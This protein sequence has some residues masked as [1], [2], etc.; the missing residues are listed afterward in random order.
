MRKISRR[1]LVAEIFNQSPERFHMR[2]TCAA[3]GSIAC[4]ESPSRMVLP[5][6]LVQRERFGTSAIFHLSHLVAI[7]RTAERGGQLP[8]KRCLTNAMSPSLVSFS[9]SDHLSDEFKPYLIPHSSLTIVVLLKPEQSA[10]KS[11]LSGLTTNNKASIADPSEWF[12][13]L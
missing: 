6:L 12:K 10:P 2:Q 7:L 5:V 1:P 4:A 8:S 9:L 3:L 13:L 11:K